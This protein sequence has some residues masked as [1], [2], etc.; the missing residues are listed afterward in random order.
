ML[1]EGVS[2]QGGC[3]SG[4]E[5]GSGAEHVPPRW[6]RRLVNG[7]GEMAGMEGVSI[8]IGSD[9]QPLGC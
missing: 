1:S 3:T 2:D 9:D 4:A 6:G 7:D 8:A 5:G